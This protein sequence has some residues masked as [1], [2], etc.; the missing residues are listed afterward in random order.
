MS[1]YAL[2][3]D[4]LTLYKRNDPLVVQRVEACP[5]DDVAI[6]VITVEEI[7]TGWYTYMRRARQPNQ[8]EFGYQQLADSV[9]FLGTWKILSFPQ[10][11]IAR[12]NQLNAL[13][14]NIGKMDLRIA[15]IVLE[16]SAILV[17]RN[18]RDF[19]RVPGLVIENWAV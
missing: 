16:H 15:A 5:P 13:R 19:Q 6:T 8:L 1:L 9:R 17:T 12:Y 18:V 7:L 11:A 14:L 2:D 10:P 4:T 3:T